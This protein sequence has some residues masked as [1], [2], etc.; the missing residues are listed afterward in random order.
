MAYRRRVWSLHPTQWYTIK[1]HLHLW[2]V[3]AS[4]VSSSLK[5]GKLI[6]MWAPVS[7][8]VYHIGSARSLLTC[9]TVTSMRLLTPNSYHF[10]TCNPGKAR[11]AEVVVASDLFYVNCGP[12]PLEAKGVMVDGKNWH[13]WGCPFGENLPDGQIWTVVGSMG[14]YVDAPA[15]LPLSGILLWPGWLLVSLLG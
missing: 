8:I 3:T 9:L 12:S 2:K 13:L 10:W 1:S 15:L 7:L 4:F 11:V 14:S 6:F 5:M